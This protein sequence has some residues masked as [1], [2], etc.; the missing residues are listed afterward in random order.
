M[1]DPKTY[2]YNRKVVGTDV[3][4]SLFTGVQQYTSARTYERKLVE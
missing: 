2:A 1:R 3:F 4:S